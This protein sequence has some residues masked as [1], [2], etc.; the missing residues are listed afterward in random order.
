[1]KDNLTKYG[2]GTGSWETHKKTRKLNKRE[3]KE[4]GRGSETKA[5]I[6]QMESFLKYL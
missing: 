6:R 5:K 4:D 2:T 1:M 3:K